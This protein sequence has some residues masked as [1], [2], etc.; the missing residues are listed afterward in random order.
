MRSRT[1]GRSC[2]GGTTRSTWTTMRLSTS[3]RCRR[4]TEAQQAVRGAAHSPA[5]EQA[6]LQQGHWQRSVALHRWACSPFAAAPALCPLQWR[7]LHQGSPYLEDYYYQAFVYKYYAKRNRR[8]FAPE[9]GELAA[10]CAA[11]MRLAGLDRRLML[12]EC[13]RA[14]LPLQRPAAMPL[15][16][17]QVWPAFMLAPPPLWPRLQCASWPPPRRW[18]PTRWPL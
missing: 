7:P 2:G 1:A 11:S 4:A 3:C 8:F 18:P 6:G 12:T 15:V 17:P 9:S 16:T 5:G 10:R 13:G 14:A